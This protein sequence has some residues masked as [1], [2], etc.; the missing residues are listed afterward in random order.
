MIKLT[1]LVGMGSF[2]GGI[3]RHLVSASIQQRP[4]STFPVNTFV[5]NIAGCFVIGCLL[6]FSERWEYKPEL[7]FFFITGFLGG[8]TTFSAFS[9]ETYHLFKNGYA[10]VA[11]GYIIA[12]VIVGVSLTFLGAWLCRYTPPTV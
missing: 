2:F 6:G 9:A 10:W 11:I 8:F 1:L 5:V 4:A 3:A 7:R 12:S